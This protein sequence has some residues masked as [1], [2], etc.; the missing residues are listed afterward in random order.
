MYIAYTM[1]VTEWRLKWRREMNETDQRA[2]T[3]AIDSLLNYETVK[4]FGN[5]EFEADRYNSALKR[6]EEH[7]LLAMLAF[8]F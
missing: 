6:Y 7:R 3:R 1:I 5:E 8:H 2:N 4:Y